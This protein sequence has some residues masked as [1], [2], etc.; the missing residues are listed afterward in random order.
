MTDFTLKTSIFIIFLRIIQKT[1]LAYDD[2]QNQNQ[3]LIPIVFRGSQNIFT[4]NE[5]IDLIEDQGFRTSPVLDEVYGIISLDPCNS[6]SLE[7]DRVDYLPIFEIPTKSMMDC[8]QYKLTLSE[9]QVIENEFNNLLISKNDGKEAPFINKSYRKNIFGLEEFTDSVIV[10]KVGQLAEFLSQIPDHPNS[11]ILIAFDDNF[12]MNWQIDR[13]VALIKKM[14]Y[15]RNK[16]KISLIVRPVDFSAHL[17]EDVNR[18]LETP[19]TANVNH[20][21]MRIFKKALK[22]ETEKLVSNS[23]YG[24]LVYTV[25]IGDPNDLKNTFYELT[26]SNNKA[27]DDVK[28]KYTS[29]V[30]WLVV[31]WVRIS[32]ED[33]SRNQKT[34]SD[35]EKNKMD[36]KTENER[37]TDRKYKYPTG[38]N[39]NNLN[40]Y[41][42]NRN[43]FLNQINTTTY[44]QL[45]TDHG[46]SSVFNQKPGYNQDLKEFLINATKEMLIEFRKILNKIEPKSG[47]KFLDVKSQNKYGFEKDHYN[48]IMQHLRKFSA[49]KSSSKNEKIYTGKL[50][51][52]YPTPNK[53]GD[54]VRMEQNMSDILD[55]CSFYKTNNNKKCDFHVQSVNGNDNNR[56]DQLATYNRDG[57]PRV[58][59]HY[60]KNYT[61][62]TL[63][64]SYNVVTIHDP[65]FMFVDEHPKG[66]GNF[67]FRGYLHD[68]LLEFQ[69]EY[70]FEAK[71]YPVGDGKYG[72][73]NEQTGTWNGLIYELIKNRAD[74][75]LAAMTIT[76][77]RARYVDF[78]CRY[79][80]FAVT[81]IMQKDT[82]HQYKL[83]SF[84]DPFSLWVWLSIGISFSIVSCLLYVL[85]RIS[86]KRMKGPRYHDTSLHGTFW[87]VFSAFVQQSTDMYLVT[88][89]AQVVTG[90]W[91]LFTLIIISNYTAKLASAMTVKNLIQPVD[92]IESLAHQKNI[93]YGTVKGSSTYDDFKKRKQ[94]EV[95][96]GLRAGPWSK[97]FE[98]I[99]QHSKDKQEE[100]FNEIATNPNYAFLWDAPVIKYKK[101]Q[102]SSCKYMT[103]DDEIFQ[104]GYGIA[105]Q[106]GSPITDKFSIAI[107]KY[108]DNGKIKELQHR[109]WDPKKAKACTNEDDPNAR[110]SD[111]T[112]M[113]LS[114][115]L[116]PFVVLA[117]GTFIGSCIAIYEVFS[118]VNK[119]K[120]YPP[121]DPKKLPQLIGRD[122]NPYLSV[123]RRKNNDLHIVLS[124]AFTSK[125]NQYKE[126][127][128]VTEQTK[129]ALQEKAQNVR[130]TVRNSLM[131]PS[132]GMNPFNLRRG[133]ANGSPYNRYRGGKEVETSSCSV[134]E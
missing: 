40:Y 116:G 64:K 132:G 22:T 7:G 44:K 28:M 47:Q 98:M 78:T 69:K 82:R 109:W 35:Q 24:A 75:S 25:M 26:E 113:K 73:L 11:V 23:Y 30:R 103:I 89:S 107:L 59:C 32:A 52:Y 88:L 65:P 71:L 54:F 61:G 74:F 79:D 46:M 31:N 12:I 8:S 119:G 19:G 1:A 49:Y 67:S 6:F 48:K 66:S 114:Q 51:A 87:F 76:P 39:Y 45:A 57:W 56:Y 108:Q 10:S 120:P 16:R 13:L 68:L 70:G 91:W 131:I 99:E 42:N 90:V 29:S 43:T 101:Y 38:R 124:N 83:F 105:T 41:K 85:N 5:L 118:Y 62:S 36:D 125:E 115:L 18:M 129:Q 37:I 126:A 77:T 58:F 122:L 95:S 93:E 121:R 112:K 53:H 100:G 106:Q 102:E 127:K 130:T 4:R 117:G 33:N 128:V 14:Y 110:I 97:I 20:E 72:S 80:N 111:Q 92:S 2:N 15:A 50:M 63:K 81:L 3:P 96:L 21:G 123:Q 133:S 9:D 55:K 34:S 134:D 86:P 104:K 17:Y 60:T 84:M 27:I 94:K